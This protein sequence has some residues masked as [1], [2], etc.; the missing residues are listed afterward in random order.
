MQ[1]EQ[2][3]SLFSKL[4]RSLFID[5]AYKELAALDRPLPIGLGQTISQ[6]S[7]VFQM[8]ALLEPYKDGCV[9]EIGTGSGYQTALLAMAAGEVYTVERI[10]ELSVK[11]RG[12]LGALGLTN[13]H[14]RVGDGSDGWI[15]FAPFDR[16]IVTAAAAAMPEPLIGQLKPGG[17]AVAPVGPKGFQQ[18]LRITKD[19]D[20]QLHTESVGTVTF[21]ELVGRY[22]WAKS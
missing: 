17:I 21:V 7:L 15:E 1:K 14:Y 12:R 8:T 16:V 4:D 13:V 2:L 10:A 20:G 11:A 6:P 19:A 18:L 5:G 9:L 22:G 3:M